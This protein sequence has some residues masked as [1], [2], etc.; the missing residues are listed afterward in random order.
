MYKHINFKLVGVFKGVLVLQSGSN[1]YVVAA[2]SRFVFRDRFR[3][4]GRWY[5][6]MNCYSVSSATFDFISDF[7]AGLRGFIFDHMFMEFLND[8]IFTICELV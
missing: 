2:N 6:V 4:R 7:N 1:L 5:R 3:Y 8:D